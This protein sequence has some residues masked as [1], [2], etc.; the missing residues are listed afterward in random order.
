MSQ[1]PKLRLSGNAYKL[2]REE[3]EKTRLV[4]ET[5]LKKF[6]A[7]NLVVT[8][9]S[10]NVDLGESS[11]KL[12]ENATEIIVSNFVI[13]EPEICVNTDIINQSLSVSDFSD[14][15]LVS[16]TDLN[17][18]EINVNSVNFSDRNVVSNRVSNTSGDSCEFFSELDEITEIFTEN[19]F[20]NESVDDNSS[21]IELDPNYFSDPGFWPSFKSHSLISELVKRGVPSKT[22]NQIFPVN[23]NRRA[24]NVSYYKRKLSNSE[25][26]D[27]EW[28]I[29]SKSTDS[30]FCF[31][32]SLFCIS[33]TSMSLGNSD[34]SNLTKILSRH[35][36]SINHHKSFN[37]WKQMEM[38]IRKETTIDKH[39][40]KIIEA[41]KLR[42]INVL[43]RIISVIKLLSSQNLAFRGSSDKLFTKHNGNFL[44][45]I[46]LLGEFDETMKDHLKKVKSKET[47]NHYLGKNTQNEIINLLAHKTNEYILNKIRNSKYFSII[48]DCTP[49]KSHREQMTIIIRFVSIDTNLESANIV[50]TEECFL[51]FFEITDS[52]GVGMANV[53]CKLLV[54]KL[55]LDIGNLRGQ[56]Y[57]NGANMRGKN[58][59]VQQ[60]IKN[61]NPRSFFVPCSS[62]SLNLVLNDAANCNV[63]S[64][65]FFDTIQCI[66]NFFSASTKRWE[67]LLKFIPKF[68]VKPLS[69]TRWESRVGAVKAIRF[70]LNEI[71][72]ALS[73]ISSDTTLIGPHG[74]K[75]RV[76]AKGILSK[77]S[78]FKF[79][80]ST[81]VW[82]DVLNEINIS[83]KFLQGIT[84][85]IIDATKSLKA[86]LDF[87]TS[88]RNDEKFYEIKQIA[89][90]IAEVV[91]VDPEFENVENVRRRKVRRQ[92]DYEGDDDPIYNQDRHFK[93]NFFFMILDTAISSVEERFE[94]LE[95]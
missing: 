55:G 82:Y 56:G 41:E 53:I 10:V 94:Q 80:C 59:G 3:R 50:Q 20:E 35:E 76:E 22:P 65:A 25:I 24:F 69:E 66:Y 40:L 23:N 29:Y 91:G 64:V 13:P 46:E 4:Q 71:M 48:I 32:C 44:K 89:S 18:S 92:F 43:K 7:K 21:S 81:V 84:V 90:E 58:L 1:K 17:A 73:T 79:I 60:I 6:L 42:W 34:W 62:H 39:Q 38:A 85:N 86:T 9:E 11:A 26:L 36:S 61:T 28:L 16:E 70:Q 54:E 93:V 63:E 83:S 95:V 8:A 78:S 47:Y 51:G 37:D 19:C 27:R 57:D 52:T 33:K 15:P 14:V 12:Q 77:I 74:T 72:K 87:I 2:K 68:T 88:Y 5:S 75:T 49:D 45:M 30:V 31:C 67:V